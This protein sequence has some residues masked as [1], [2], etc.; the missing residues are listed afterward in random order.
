MSSSQ[1]TINWLNALLN[2]IANPSNH[3]GPTYAA[4]FLYI[5]STI[6]YYVM[7]NNIDS[8][9]TEPELRSIQATD[10]NSIDQNYLIYISFLHLYNQ[11]G[12]NKPYPQ[13]FP[14]IPAKSLTSTEQLFYNNLVTFLN[15]RDNDG[16]K[17]ANN[18]APLSSWSPD[19]YP[20]GNPNNIYIDVDSTQSL[21]MLLPQPK[22]WTPL[23]QTV[24]SQLVIQTY[25][26][27]R[28]GD[29]VTPPAQGGTPLPLTFYMNVADSNFQDPPRTD[30]RTMEIQDLLN[31][32]QGT[33]GQAL[34]NS[35]R[36][37]AEYFQ[38]GKV[39]PPGI[40]NIWAIYAA[41][42]TNLNNKQF[43]KF[44]YWL[45]TGMFLAS[46]A[47]WKIKF[48]Y[49]QS[50]PIQ[51]IRLL[52]S[53]YV[54]TWDGSTVLNNI[55]KPYQ[56]SSNRTPPFPDFMSGH[57]TFSNAAAV[58]FDHFFPQQ[59]D[60]MLLEPFSDSHAEMISPVL[61][62][63]NTHTNKYSNSVKFI[64]CDVQSSAVSKGSSSVGFPTTP[65]TLNFSNWH[66]LAQLSGIS[67][68]YGGIHENTANHTALII[69][70]Q[71]GKD[72]VSSKSPRTIAF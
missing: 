41:K 34:T 30:A 53:Q 26:T 55:W 45:N 7:S 11:P 27:P 62:D 1:I 3:M 32:Y 31:V 63:P 57:S 67:R 14:T 49:K 35:Q 20:N 29:V 33:N 18:G 36:V 19:V 46:I 61:V 56:Q 42:S 48:A 10:I 70:Q 52:Q 44:L 21:S 54:T 51:D 69:G 24:N 68:I 50:R 15:I 13:N 43:S 17:N 65:I 25:L 59:L 40:W 72:V 66:E 2:T 16:W 71:I 37:I 9:I 22:L 28:W 23:R 4:R 64:Q 12:P 5:G 58:I 60:T 47:C 6:I 8:D 38:G 39:S